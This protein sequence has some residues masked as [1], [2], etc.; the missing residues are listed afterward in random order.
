MT[1]LG[2]LEPFCDDLID[3]KHSHNDFLMVKNMK[4]LNNIVKLLVFSKQVQLINALC[5]TS[6]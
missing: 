2:L 5:L 3:S 6:S 1:T 4:K